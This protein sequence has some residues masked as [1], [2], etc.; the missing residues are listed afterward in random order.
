MCLQNVQNI[1]YSL[2]ERCNVSLLVVYLNIG[3]KMIDYSNYYDIAFKVPWIKF[4]NCTFTKYNRQY[5]FPLT[6]G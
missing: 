4:V 6:G 5:R 2:T 3:I 1:A